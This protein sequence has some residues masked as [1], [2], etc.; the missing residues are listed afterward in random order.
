MSSFKLIPDWF[1]S[2]STK[3]SRQNNLGS[4]QEVTKRT[5]LE[6][7]CKKYLN[8][9]HAGHLKQL[10]VLSLLE[11]HLRCFIYYLKPHLALTS[12]QGLWAQIYWNLWK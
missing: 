12:T 3:K 6:K 9:L 2:Q 8:I 5:K 7:R 4:K 1:I 11:T 10:T